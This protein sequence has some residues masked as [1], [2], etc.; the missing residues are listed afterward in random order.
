M[1]VFAGVL[2]NN[3]GTLAAVDMQ[4]SAQEADAYAISVKKDGNILSRLENG[5]VTA[6]FYADSNSVENGGAVTL[7]TAYYQ[8]E[9]LVDVAYDEEKSAAD[10]PRVL[11]AGVTV[12]DSSFGNSVKAFLLESKETIRP[13]QYTPKVLGGRGD[14]ASAETE[15]AMQCV[16]LMNVVSP[17]IFTYKLSENAVVDN[18]RDGIQTAQANGIAFDENGAVGNGGSLVYEI[19]S[20]NAWIV[21]DKRNG[22]YGFKAEFTSDGS[23]YREILPVEKAGFEFNGRMYSIYRFSSFPQQNGW[24]KITLNDEGLHIRSVFANI[25]FSDESLVNTVKSYFPKEQSSASVTLEKL[26]S[27]KEVVLKNMG[28]SYTSQ[29]FDDTMLSDG[30][31]SDVDYSSAQAY[32]HMQRCRE[33]ALEIYSVQENDEQ[34]ASLSKAVDYYFNQK[35]SLGSSWYANHITLPQNISEILLLAGNH[36]PKQTESVMRTY[37]ENKRTYLN[38]V[39]TFTGAN[40]LEISLWMINFAL[41]TSD[42]ENLRFSLNKIESELMMITKL[43]SK[44]DVRKVYLNG[45]YSGLPGIQTDY[46]GLFHESQLYSGGYCMTLVKKTAAFLADAYESGL[47]DGMYLEDYIDHILEHYRWIFYKKQMDFNTVGRYIALMTTDE[48]GN[49]VS[50]SPTNLN[51]ASMKQTLSRLASIDGIYRSKELQEFSRLWSAQLSTTSYAE[52]NRYFY[53]P[54]YMVNQKGSYMASLRMSSDRVNGSE[55][56]SWCNLKGKYLADGCL[57]VYRTTEEF[58]DI[59]AAWDWNKIPGTTPFSDKEIVYSTKQDYKTP[60]SADKLAG[61]VSDGNHGVAAMQLVREGLS[62][63]KA[64]FMFDDEIVCLGNDISNTTNYS[65][66]TTVNQC[67]TADK[68]VIYDGNS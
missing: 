45:V 37:L 52:G 49:A 48:S 53:K 38:S 7:V 24:L 60:G 17:H 18:L 13:L 4:N 35:I 56:V 3:S 62:A 61:G 44:Y 68:P 28:D 55:Q 21:T 22:D 36:L 25:D 50:S 2:D 57:Y 10:N 43:E 12:N 29:S 30:S 26:Q 40:E 65:A 1:P 14:P 5:N 23:E 66:V 15:L 58:N 42:T 16:Y 31:W 19:S 63:K 8:D 6:E 34:I 64:W 41:Y 11:S 59:F 54:Y 27:Y 20:Q 51:G 32:V 67:I 47:T 39:Y 46:S 33:I 9:K